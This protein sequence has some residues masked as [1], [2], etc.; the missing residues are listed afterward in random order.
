MSVS[1]LSTQQRQAIESYLALSREL[2]LELERRLQAASGLSTADWELIVHLLDAGEAG[3]RPTELAANAGW[4]TSRVAHQLR[5]MER[6][7]LV[8]RCAHP[9]DGRGRIVRLTA[10]GRRRGLAAAPVVD[11]SLRELVVGA[12]AGDQLIA[13]GAACQR[14]LDRVRRTAPEAS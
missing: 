1:S 8:E 9:E 10:E 14:V 2:F 13:W 4:P 11:G 7:A 6:R 5:R 3:Q 12:L